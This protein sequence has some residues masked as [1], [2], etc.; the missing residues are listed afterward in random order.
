MKNAENLK[1]CKREQRALIMISIGHR[2]IGDIT[3]AIANFN[4]AI[5]IANINND[6]LAL[7]QIKISLGNVY[8][9]LD[10][11]Q[12]SIEY[13]ISALQYFS[14]SKKFRGLCGCYIDLSDALFKSNENDKAL[15]YLDK[16]K[17]LSLENGNKYLEYILTNSG[18]VYFNKKDYKLAKENALAGKAIAEKAKN[19][20]ML[21]SEYLLLSKIYLAQD[22]LNNARINVEMGLKLAKQTGIKEILINSYFL[23]S[24][25]LEKQNDFKEALK[26]KTLY[27]TTKDSLQSTINHNLLQAYELEKKD[28]EMALMKFAE[29][30]NDAELKKQH[31]ISTI[32][33]A[34]LLLVI[35]F[36]GYVLY[37]SKKLKKSNLDLESANS[38]INKKQKEIILQNEELV[39]INEQIKLQSKHIEELN[40]VKDWLFAIISHD[41]GTPFNNL[42]GILNLLTSGNLSKEKFQTIIP[43]LEKSVSTASGLL[44]NLL[45]WSNNQLKG[46]AIECSNFEIKLLVKKQID[47]F[48]K[49]ANDKQIILID[50]IPSGT[51]VF[52]DYNMIDVVLRNLVANAIKFCNEGG[53]ISI[54]HKILETG[55]EISVQ[56]EGIGI[57]SDDLSKIFQEKGKFSTL[58]TKKEVGT[59]LGLLLCKSFIEKL[60]GKIGV[61]SK[62]N[63]G[64]KFWFILPIS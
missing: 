26:F 19:L 8:K 17:K 61:E 35:C 42:K 43:M 56:D 28:E 10:N 40:N 55:V 34:T 50:Q 41:L 59:G 58:G 39:V 64:S 29:I 31:L 62:L 45:Q 1:D 11:Q 44:D 36:S 57:A 21:S 27:V 63:E 52:A 54:A 18:E 24:Q 3:T 60:N 12:L 14:T 2:Y 22:D 4:T 32:I 5:K 30:Q 46:E 6:Q 15:Y 53:K 9:A 33:V 49:Q 16:A 20:Y 25:T 23:Y 37:T 7:A 51:I 48:E 38:E 47:L 13:Y